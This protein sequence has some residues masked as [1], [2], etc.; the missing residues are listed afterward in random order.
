MMSKGYWK[1]F[2]TS[3]ILFRCLAEAQDSIHLLDH[4]DLVGHLLQKA[5]K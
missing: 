1:R 3:Q 5:W 4:E 2:I